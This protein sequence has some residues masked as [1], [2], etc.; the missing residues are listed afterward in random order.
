MKTTGTLQVVAQGEREVL[1]TRVFDAPRAL[2]FKALTTPALLKRW[3]GPQGWELVECEVDLRVGGAWR[4]L[5]RGP[6]DRTMGMRGTYREIAP[7]GRL[8]YTESFDD[9]DV[10]E[11]LVTVTLVEENGRTT[12]TNLVLSPSREVRDAVLKSGMERGAAEVYDRLAALLP[13]LARTTDA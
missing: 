1:M 9:F 6:G 4:F 13:S 5:S 8:Q 3:F 2:V 10:G 7:P 11:A 12:L